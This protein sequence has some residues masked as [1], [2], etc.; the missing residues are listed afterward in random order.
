MTEVAARV[1][2]VLEAVRRAHKRVTSAK[3][4]VA[5]VLAQDLD[6]LTAD[7]I[8]SRTQALEPAVSPS[9]V[10]RILDEFEDL[11]VVEHTHLDQSAAVFHLA[12]SAHA[13]LRCEECGQTLLIP[14]DTLDELRDRVRRTTGFDLD[15][16]HVALSG[17][18]AG[19][20]TS[21]TE[22]MP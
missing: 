11:D 15:V 5:R 6:H 2:D 17:L 14:A 20:R 13:H 3:R 22:A 7:E 1:D 21:E 18:C 12:G 19:C 16:H 8:Y 9:T 10:Y 4:A